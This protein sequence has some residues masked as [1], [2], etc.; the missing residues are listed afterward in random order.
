MLQDV[1]RQLRHQQPVPADLKQGVYRL[2]LYCRP[3][4]GS[5]IQSGH[6]LNGETIR[7]TA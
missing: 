1:P 7:V 4:G 2:Y 5:L 3:C 6:H